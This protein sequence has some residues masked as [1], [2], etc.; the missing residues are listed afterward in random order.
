MPR[1]A[2]TGI[3]LFITNCRQWYHLKTVVLLCFL[4]LLPRKR[5]KDLWYSLSINILGIKTL[6]CV[7]EI[8]AAVSS[9]T[10]TH[11]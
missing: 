9:N 10:E 3:K 11:K 8:Q 6:G 1:Y 7:S 2:S 5:R 4:A